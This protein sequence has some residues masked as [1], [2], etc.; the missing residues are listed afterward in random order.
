[1]TQKH[2]LE[3][4]E[5]EGQFYDAHRIVDTNGV[6]ICQLWYKDESPM[7]NQESN[8]AR[9]V[10]CVNAMAGIDDPETWMKT[11]KEVLEGN[12]KLQANWSNVIE[13]LRQD[14]DEL[15]SALKNERHNMLKRGVTVENADSFNALDKLIAKHEGRNGIKK[16]KEGE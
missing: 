6:P 4:W 3:P 5:V 8:A 12:L 15:L 14:S 2:T 13:Q 10:A 11:T 7:P 9:I 1:M 16:L